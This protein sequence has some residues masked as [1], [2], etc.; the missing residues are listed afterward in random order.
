M[1]KFKDLDRAKINLSKQK[2]Y[3]NQNRQNHKKKKTSQNPSWNNYIR[4][5]KNK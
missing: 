3:D 1:E 4:I 2:A 5:S